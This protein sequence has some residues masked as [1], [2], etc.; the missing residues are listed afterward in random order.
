ME[1]FANLR[2]L[3]GCMINRERAEGSASSL[4]SVG[5]LL[6]L[7]LFLNRLALSTWQPALNQA[8]V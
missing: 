6:A 3:D 7:S 8:E 2:A 5:N 4:T 1:S